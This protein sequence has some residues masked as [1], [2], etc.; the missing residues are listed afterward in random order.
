VKRLEPIGSGQ[1]IP[2][3]A[4]QQI[5]D[6]IADGD[7]EGGKLPPETVLAAQLGVSRTAL[8]EALQRLES[9]G[10]IARRRKVGTVVLANRLKLDAGLERLNSV[11]QIVEDAGMEPGTA[12]IEWR[13]E[14]ANSLI[15]QRLQISAGDEVTVMERV[16]TADGTR[17]CYDINFLPAMY[18]SPDEQACVGESLLAYLSGKYG[19]I[20]QAVAYL[21]PYV[22]DAVV[23]EKLEIAVGHLLMLL[24]HTHYTAEGRPMWYSRTFH[25]SDVISFHIVRSL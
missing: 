6:Y 13:Q 10:Y 18:V 19:R 25:R 23:S 20:R 17:F 3:R 2:S 14:T 22:A 21:Y 9:Q 1:S 11:T 7:I 15:A 12:F 8:R 16:R 24:E 4:Y 5:L